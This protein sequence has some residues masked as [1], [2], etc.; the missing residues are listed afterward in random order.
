MMQVRSRLHFSAE[1]VN[2][3]CFTGGRV[4]QLKGRYGGVLKRTNGAG[5][6]G[7]IGPRGGR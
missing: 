3:R 1:R 7:G 5:A 6:R 4:K 2:E